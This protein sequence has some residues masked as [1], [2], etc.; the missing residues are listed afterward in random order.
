MN[1]K[2]KLLLSIFGFIFFAGLYVLVAKPKVVAVEK[3]KVVRGDFS[4]M[5]EADGFFRSK[6]KFTVTAFS[7]GDIKRIEL[8]VGD[9]LKKN[10]TITE[11]FWD[12]RYIP[13]KA[14]AN[15][16]ITKIFHESAGPVRRG[17]PLVEMMDPSDLEIVAELLTTDAAKVK[18]GGIA[19]A[20]G[21]GS[22]EKITATVK[23][24]SKAGF[25]KISAL[26]VEEE[27]TEVLMNP[28]KL[29]LEKSAKLGH[30]FH[31]Q[32][33]IEVTHHKNVLKIPTGSLIR[34]GSNWA[35]YL[36][37]NDK[38]KLTHITPGPRGNTEVVVSQGLQD[39][40]LVINFPGELVKDGTSVK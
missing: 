30:T 18:E 24:I 22:D 5:I 10:Q 25:V 33:Q 19:I 16:V 8:R 36:V 14:P 7:D 20:S 31:T 34:D 21:F 32:L 27:R 13:V 26:G 35:V 2:L 4:E 29:S 3:V 28:G 15:G 37:K 12:V 17:E 40:D 1:K 38:A 6:N 9:V 23:K 11:L 39:D